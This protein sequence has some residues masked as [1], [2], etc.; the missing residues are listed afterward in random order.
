MAA[1]DTIAYFIRDLS[2]TST[3]FPS[4]YTRSFRRAMASHDGSAG[5]SHVPEKLK[6]EQ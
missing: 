1:G 4:L 2:S 3:Q 6:P 5:H